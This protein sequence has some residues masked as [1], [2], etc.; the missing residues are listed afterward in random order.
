[1]GLLWRETGCQSAEGGASA[2][3]RGHDLEG[4]SIRVIEAKWHVCIRAKLYHGYPGIVLVC[5][6]YLR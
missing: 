4:G 5:H 6:L 2:A 3:E 1:M